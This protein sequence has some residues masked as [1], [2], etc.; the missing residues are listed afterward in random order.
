M[1]LLCTEGEQLKRAFL[2]PVFISDN[3]VLKN[4]LKTE[5]HY[6]VSSKYMDFQTDIKPYMRKVV[7]KWML[8]V[9]KKFIAEIYFW[10]Q[11]FIVLSLIV[12]KKDV[13]IT[14]FIVFP[15]CP[16]L[17]SRMKP[18]IWNFNIMWKAVVEKVAKVPGHV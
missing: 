3:R 2:D 11:F 18:N 6:A 12:S 8:E 13:D 17:D 1:E 5:E 15:I 9:I 4:L 10:F 14:L 16:K 7:T